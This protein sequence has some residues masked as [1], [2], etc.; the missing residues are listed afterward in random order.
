MF[1]KFLTYDDINDIDTCSSFSLY[2]VTYDDINDIDTCSSFSLYKA[3]Y[4]FE[5]YYLL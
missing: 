4:N 3:L 5:Y 2:K 1:I